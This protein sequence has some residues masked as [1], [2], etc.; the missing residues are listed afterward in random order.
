[1]YEHVPQRIL[2]RIARG[3]RDA[4]MNG[5]WAQLSRRQ[6]VAPPRDRVSDE[7]AAW[8][9]PL[10][11]D[12]SCTGLNGRLCVGVE[13]NAPPYAS[14]FEFQRSRVSKEPDALGCVACLKSV[15]GQQDVQPTPCPGLL[16]QSILCVCPLCGS[17]V[18]DPDES[19]STVMSPAYGSDAYVA[20]YTCQLDACHIVNDLCIRA[21]LLFDWYD[22]FVETLIRQTLE[23]VQREGCEP[24]HAV[25]QREVVYGGHRPV[26]I[27]ASAL[28]SYKL[29]TRTTDADGEV[30]FEATDA[31]KASCVA[32]M[33]ARTAAANA[34][35]SLFD[36]NDLAY[37]AK[38]VQRI[39]TPGQGNVIGGALLPTPRPPPGEEVPPNNIFLIPDCF[40]RK[41]PPTSSTIQPLKH[42]NSFDLPQMSELVFETN[43]VLS[44]TLH[45]GTTVAW[46]VS[47][48]LVF[49]VNVASIITLI[50]MLEDASRVH[51]VFK[52]L[53]PHALVGL[54]RRPPEPV[55][56]N[57]ARLL[58][59]LQLRRRPPRVIA[60][61]FDSVNDMPHPTACAV[62]CKPPPYSAQG[63]ESGGD[64]EGLVFRDDALLQETREVYTCS[65][66]SEPVLLA[67][68]E[69]RAPID[70][71]RLAEI[72]TYYPARFVGR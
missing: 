63:Y 48:P 11:P 72:Q 56:V 46:V 45:L 24:E 17:P 68:G 16:S 31:L 59:C 32:F 30:E 5:R 40:F 7:V 33:F 66:D 52:D 18:L 69:K 29:V 58:A 4:F 43:V 26:D 6:R 15:A 51:F 50:C 12:D 23:R 14:L 25:M 10:I 2:A 20:H 55:S 71:E 22:A 65:A 13:A 27:D 38:K 34:T 64:D 41:G 9:S 39:Q 61:F 70:E 62:L 67:G 28:E 44:T 36:L 8:M 53:A 42:H 47:H 21:G 54:A 35:P 1:M 49:G 3:T 60:R 57:A 19:H 37:L